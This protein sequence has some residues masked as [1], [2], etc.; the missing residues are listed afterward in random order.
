MK[1][2]INWTAPVP[3]LPRLLTKQNDAWFGPTLRGK[4]QV[5]LNREIPLLLPLECHPYWPARGRCGEG[6]TDTPS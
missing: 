1:A 3:K 6:S 5:G 4:R 2:D